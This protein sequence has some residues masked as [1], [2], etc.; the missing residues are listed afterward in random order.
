MV[1]FLGLLMG[2]LSTSTDWALGSS[3]AAFTISRLT[4]YSDSP[5]CQSLFFC[6][7][8]KGYMPL[9]WRLSRARFAAVLSISLNPYGDAGRVIKLSS[10]LSLLALTTANSVAPP[11]DR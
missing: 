2:V 9:G 1:F 4:G 10:P 8:V 7:D 6:P 5:F 3:N 11:T